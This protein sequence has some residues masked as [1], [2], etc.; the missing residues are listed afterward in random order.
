MPL[1]VETAEGKFISL[2]NVLDPIIWRYEFSLS[3]LCH[4]AMLVTD[5]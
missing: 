1:V 2:Y 4:L 3:S 5:S